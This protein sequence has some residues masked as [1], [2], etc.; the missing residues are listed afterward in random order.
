M[1]VNSGVKTSKLN[2]LI[3][4]APGVGKTVLAASAIEVP[5]CGNVLFIDV[6]NGLASVAHYGDKL[7]YVPV[8]STQEFE[9]VLKD[10]AGVDREKYQ[11]VII[12][13]I[14][15]LS[16]LEIQAVARAATEKGNKRDNVDEV[17]LVDHKLRGQKL[18]RLFGL[19]KRLP[20][21]IVFLSKAGKEVPKDAN[22][23]PIPGAKATDI[24]PE[25]PKR[26]R[27]ELMGAVD[28]AGFLNLESDGSRKLY[29]EQTGP[30]QAKSRV[31][32]VTGVLT[33]PTMKD[34]FNP[35]GA[36]TK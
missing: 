32:G 28:I 7:K 36:T 12:D 5:A 16:E 22:G 29:L 25:V 3:Y 23:L 35:K 33:N 11:T 13:S 1:Q 30:I 10:L 2:I 15:E 4:A 20:Q 8:G 19:A 14:T 18:N 21:N 34:I 6:D 17:H 31:R 24:Y 27:G 9:T 26:V